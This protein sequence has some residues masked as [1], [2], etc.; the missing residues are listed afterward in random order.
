MFDR[1]TLV[2]IFE[3]PLRDRQNK[4]CVNSECNIIIIKLIII[5]WTTWSAFQKY[6]FGTKNGR[7]RLT[8]CGA[9]YN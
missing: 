1:K 7:K 2:A 5:L 9:F 6:V 3:V 4:Y 8:Y